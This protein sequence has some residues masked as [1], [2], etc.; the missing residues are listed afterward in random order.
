[1]EV[2]DGSLLQ[3]LQEDLIQKVQHFKV[4]RTLQ[5]SGVVLDFL[6][7]MLTTVWSCSTLGA[8]RGRTLQAVE[9][10]LH[11]A[12]V[13]LDRKMVAALPVPPSYQESHLVRFESEDLVVVS[14]PPHWQVDSST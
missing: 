10:F 6:S 4:S 11:D 14:K 13:L 2:H 12:A 9:A 5:Q 8:L 7:S 3:T 1:M